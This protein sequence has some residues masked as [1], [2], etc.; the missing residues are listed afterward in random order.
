MLLGLLLSALLVS[1]AALASG[2]R[3]YETG[4][5]VF[6]LPIEQARG[7]LALRV[8]G[9]SVG[10]PVAL[11]LAPASVFALAGA[12]GAC[13]LGTSLVTGFD[14]SALRRSMTFLGLTS[15]AMTV[16][17]LRF[18]TVDLDAAHAA[19]VVIGPGPIVGPPL[20]AG[21]SIAALLIGWVSGGFWLS[22]LP[23]LPRFAGK[24]LRSGET[25]LVGAAVTACAWG[26][27]AA[28]FARGSL[29]ID[30]VSRAGVSLLVTIAAVALLAIARR[31][32]PR[33]SQRL[34]LTILIPLTGALVIAVVG[35]HVGAL[36]S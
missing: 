29:S 16:A 22:S 13:A 20:A 24:L 21:L 6:S 7:K 4:R 34:A 8:F 32:F 30:A 5:D 36:S 23:E 14:G 19:Q 9:V 12:L 15:T 35:L 17:T 1:V 26:P 27:S 33:I 11:G 31:S 25:A 18:G 3:V 28:P 2:W 10:I